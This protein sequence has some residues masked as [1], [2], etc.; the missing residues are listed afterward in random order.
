MYSE[1]AFQ[2]L[3]VQHESGLF[4]V[5]PVSGLYVFLTVN[6]P[7]SPRLGCTAIH[8]RF[9]HW[10]LVSAFKSEDPV[11][12]LCSAWKVARGAHGWLRCNSLPCARQLPVRV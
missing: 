7:S 9:T 6:P 3:F 1:F 12:V 2:D 4:K 11:K 5:A 8:G 10:A